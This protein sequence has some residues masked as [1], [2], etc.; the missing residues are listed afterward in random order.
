MR[1]PVTFPR[2]ACRTRAR[3]HRRGQTLVEYALVLAVLTVVMV[4]CM[5]L[6]GARIVLVFSEITAVLDT[7]QSSH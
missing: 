1:F 3:R 5:K 4:A 2:A 7:A 6:L